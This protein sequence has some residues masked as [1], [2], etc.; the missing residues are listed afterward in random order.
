MYSLYVALEMGYF[1][2]K[3]YTSD[4]LYNEL[5]RKYTKYLEPIINKGLNYICSSKSLISKEPDRL[6]KK[7]VLQFLV[8]YKFR[9]DIDRNIKVKKEK[10]GNEEHIVTYVY[11]EISNIKILDGSF[12]KFSYDGEDANLNGNI[13][14][15]KSFIKV[16]NKLLKRKYNFVRLADT[17]AGDFFTYDADYFFDYSSNYLSLV[18]VLDRNSFIYHEDHVGFA[19]K[20][21]LVLYISKDKLKE[22]R[23]NIVKLIKNSKI[24]KFEFKLSDSKFFIINKLDRESIRK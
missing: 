22:L 19:N 16:L 1:E 20:K 10:V 8:L 12:I 24:D 21:E 6:F 17:Q 7:E 13:K 23:N 9:H 3:D 4:K 2:P 11:D 5:N 14:G 18:K 15:L